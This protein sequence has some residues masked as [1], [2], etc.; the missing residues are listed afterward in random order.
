MM[1]QKMLVI[2]SGCVC[3]ENPSGA[4]FDFQQFLNFKFAKAS[5]LQVERLNSQMDPKGPSNDE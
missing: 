3:G 1:L 2:K 4:G 5:A